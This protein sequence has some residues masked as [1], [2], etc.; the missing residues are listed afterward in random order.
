VFVA[1]YIRTYAR[2]LDLDPKPLVQQFQALHPGAEVAPPVVKPRQPGQRPSSGSGGLLLALLL[3]ALVLGGGGYLGYRWWTDRQSAELASASEPAPGPDQRLGDVA[4]PGAQPP[5]RTPEIWP[6]LDSAD[7]APAAGAPP[8]AADAA[9]EPAEPA[10]SPI[11]WADPDIRVQAGMAPAT[12]EPALS[13]DAGGPR[14]ADAAGPMP[15]RQTMPEDTATEEETGTAGAAPE[16]SDDASADADMAPAEAGTDVVISF[17]GPCWVDIRD[18]SGETL[19]FGEMGDGDRRELGGKP[20]YSLVLG[21]ASVVDMTVGGR[22]FDV[23]AI[24]KGNVA[25]FD[26]DPAEIADTG[27]TGDTGDTR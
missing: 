22:P 17:S 3:A 18:A 14:E 16:T 21:N 12:D 11:I 7:R 5:E 10:G 2:L 8:S 1:G 25:R 20:P 6:T 24:A 4:K 26:L 23:R 15:E 27:D 19:L 13:G 9:S